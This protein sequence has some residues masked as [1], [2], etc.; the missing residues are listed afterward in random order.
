MLTGDAGVNSVNG[1]AGDDVITGMGGADTLT[2]STGADTFAYT[3]LSD[4]T[5]AAIDFITDF[6]VTLNDKIDLP[7]NQV[8]FFN[9]GVISASTLDAALRLAFD[10]KDLLTAGNQPLQSNEIVIFQWGTSSLRRNT[11]IASPDGNGANF[12]GD[13]LIKLPNAPG[14]ITASTFI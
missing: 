10:D 11:Y 8:G 14:T 4:S 12:N 6:S 2:G 3:S 7:F 9:R 13:L 5:L 1:L